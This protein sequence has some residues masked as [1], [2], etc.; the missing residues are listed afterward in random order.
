MLVVRLRF[1]RGGLPDEGLGI[2]VPVLGP[3][4]DRVGEVSDG[5]EHAT[6]EPFIG[7]FL[8]PA[9]DEI[10]PGTRRRGGVHVPS[11]TVLVGQPLCDLRCR[12]P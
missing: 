8:E 7:Q 5:G 11:A 9:F 2:A 12:V 10:E 1:V 6:T 3:K 4:G